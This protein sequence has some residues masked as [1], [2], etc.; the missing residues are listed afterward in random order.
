MASLLESPEE[1][2]RLGRAAAARVERDFDQEAMMDRL[3]DLLRA[4][5]RP[6]ATARGSA[7]PD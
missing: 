3:L 6:G 7:S 2:A 1:R 5:V 4:T